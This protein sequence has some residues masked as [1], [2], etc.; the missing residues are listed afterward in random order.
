MYVCMKHDIET[1]RVDPEVGK[2]YLHNLHKL[3]LNLNENNDGR[4][5]R[6]S[7]IH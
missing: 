4:K 5:R 6:N 7:I 1:G 2:A 3:M